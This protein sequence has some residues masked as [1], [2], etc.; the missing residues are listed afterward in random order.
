[1]LR[2]DNMISQEWYDDDNEDYD[3]YK[4]KAAIKEEHDPLQKPQV[5]V[6]T[7]VNTQDYSQQQRGYLQQKCIAGA[8]LYP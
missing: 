2:T 8:G 5:P 6:F 7:R 4:L 1:M 3:A